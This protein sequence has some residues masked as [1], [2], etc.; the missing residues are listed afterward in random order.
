MLDFTFHNPTKIVFGKGVIARLPDLI[1]AGKKVMLVTGGESIRRNGVYEQIRR[2]MSGRAMVEFFGI[3]PN[4]LYETCLKAVGQARAEKVDFLLSAGGGSPLDAAKFIAAAVP[5]IGKDPWDMFYDWSLVPADPL[6]LGCILTLPATG[7][8]ANGGSVVSRKATQEKRFF[9]SERVF[10]QFSL[11]DPQTTF[12]LPPRQTANGVVDAFVH[13][14]EQYL[15]YD[16]DA[17][18]QDRQA[19]AILRTLI[20]EGPKALAEPENYNVRAN[21]MWCATNALNGLIGC[22]VPQDWATHA[23][24]HE[25]TALFGLDHAQTLAVVYPG[26]MQHTRRRKREKLLQY[27]ARVWQLEA[28]DVES[29]INAAIF[30]T[31]EFFRS[32]GVHT[33]LKDYDISATACSC[34]IAN[35]LA[36]RYPLGE[37]E[38][39]SSQDVEAI[40]QLRA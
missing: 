12:S 22:G 33:R 6:P 23:I 17:P 4:P 2:A 9:L 31:E 16:V 32:L 30:K 29:R 11:L 25:L 3:E 13:V 21:L 5:Y 18:L 7:S 34:L 24:G 28:V 38:D 1:P 36:Q 39:L 40:L 27:A 19:E 35:R 8:E 37:R 14:L 20:E 10:P 15:T 26:M